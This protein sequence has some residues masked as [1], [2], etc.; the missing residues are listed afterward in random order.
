MAD[1]YGQRRHPRIPVNWPVVVQTPQGSME[2]KT[3][4]ISPDGAFIEYS[5]RPE[6]EKSF[7]IVFKPSD[8]QPILVTGEKVWSG[9]FNI[10]GKTVFSGMGVRFAAISSEDRELIA[11]LVND[12]SK[13]TSVERKEDISE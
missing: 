11:S 3:R 5:D 1:P 10:D 9:S 4:N 6:L 2:A 7:Q 8:R 13:T 12:Y